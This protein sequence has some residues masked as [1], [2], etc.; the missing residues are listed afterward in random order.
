MTTTMICALTKK[1]ICFADHRI[2][3]SNM[4]NVSLIFALQGIIRALCGY[5]SLTAN[6]CLF[7]I[8]LA[9]R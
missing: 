2:E 1:V 5:F 9:D 6:S 7:T 4:A 3:L 8:V